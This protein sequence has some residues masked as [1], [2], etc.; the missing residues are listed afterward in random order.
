M[1][2]S[3]FLEKLKEEYDLFD[4][5]DNDEVEKY[6]FDDYD[7]L[8]IRLNKNR[9]TFDIFIEFAHPLYDYEQYK[10]EGAVGIYYAQYFEAILKEKF[11]A[12]PEESSCNYLGAPFD[13]QR[14]GY[15][16]IDF[17]ID[18]V[19]TFIDAYDKWIGTISEV[20]SEFEGEELEEEVILRNLAFSKW[21]T[22]KK[23]IISKG[24]INKSNCIKRHDGTVLISPKYYKKCLN[25]D[26]D[27]LVEVDIQ[28]N[29]IEF[30]L[31]K[32]SAREIVA[33]KKSTFDEVI[34]AIQLIGETFDIN[35][36]TDSAN[37]VY[38]ETESVCGVLSL[39]KNID[40]IRTR[41]YE[42]LSKA[43]TTFKDFAP[44]EM[45]SKI[46]FENLDDELFENLAMDLL[47]CEGY[48]D[49]HPLGRTRASDGGRDFF[50]KRNKYSLDGNI[51]EQWIVQCKYSRSE[52]SKYFRREMFSEVPDLLGENDSD[53]FLLLTTSN[54]TPQTVDRIRYI[55]K[56]KGDI[57]EFFAV[58]ELKLA[59]YK[60]PKLIQKYGLI[61]EHK[62]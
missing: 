32:G 48:Y 41:E 53:K 49:I 21:E 2:Y 25:I 24:Y 4:Y 56:S 28:H 62:D 40:Y 7:N 33:I 36:Y 30:I 42:Y 61:K 17:D 50:A 57:I 52:K 1:D 55:N 18:F 5:C 34:S 26:F 13:D 20:M 44:P 37:I 47:D 9:Y 29:G 22:L 15:F 54:L 60:H 58:S 59:L 10:H 19:S 6:S 14:I 16:N 38:F 39:A 23:E 31:L 12:N 8:F 3:E 45:V 35:L 43:F 46:T 27:N 51:V 11:L